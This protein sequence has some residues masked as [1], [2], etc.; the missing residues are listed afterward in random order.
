MAHKTYSD[1]TTK[2][3]ITVIGLVVIAIVLK[4]L[5][6]IFIPFVIA[7][8]L[9][10]VFAPLNNFLTNKKVPGFIITILDLIITA[11]VLYGA[12]R[13]VVDSLLQFADGLP[14]YGAKLN[15][16]V[17]D[18]AREL[19]IRDPFFR[20][21]DLEQTLQRLDYKSLA[22]GIFGTTINLIGSVLFVLFFFVFVVAGEKTVYEAIKNYYVTRKVK[23]QVKRIKKSLQSSQ[24]ENKRDLELELLH[25][26]LLREKQLADTFN[27]ITNQIQRYVIAKFGINLI[28]GIVA[29]VALSAAGLDYP[30]VWG[31]F[32]FLFNFIPTIG[33]AIALVLPFL[34]A[35]VQFDSTGSAILI[36]VIMAIIQTLAFNLAEPMIIG[37]RLNLNPLL[38][39]LS[40]LIWGYI[41]GIIGM[42]IS[43][44]ITAII[45]IIL[46]NSKSRYLR[47]L[48]NL[49]S[50]SQTNP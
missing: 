18:F 33:S 32:V 10:F 36:A 46:S 47:F 8:F 28:A 48:S 12:G 41:W 3:F 16:I 30:I 13:I 4:E 50:Q 23:P 19:N 25:E 6:H 17:R 5:S 34:F 40:V 35:L 15:S 43:V 14:T 44:P 37:R 31:L 20:K 38:I 27:T 49:M 26:K 7:I 24:A 11:A 39:L 42:L 1:N 21:F 2:F 29:S 9:F 22:G 45:K